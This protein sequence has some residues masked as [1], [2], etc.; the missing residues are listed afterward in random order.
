MPLS[1]TAALH[2]MTNAGCLKMQFFN[3]RWLDHKSNLSDAHKSAIACD[4]EA[5]S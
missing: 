3:R 5:D 1:W 2:E 4:E